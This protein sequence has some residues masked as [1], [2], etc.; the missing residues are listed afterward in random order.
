MSYT[1]PEL[2][3]G[4]QGRPELTGGLSF[5]LFFFLFLLVLLFVGLFLV[6]TTEALGD[7]GKHR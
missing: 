3:R 4:H 1:G 5:L 6:I 7:A 2:T